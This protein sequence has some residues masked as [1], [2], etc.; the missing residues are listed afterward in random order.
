MLH[1]S[2]HQR[3]DEDWE[4][5]FGGHFTD[6][7]NPSCSGHKSLAEF[8]SHCIGGRLILR[9]MPSYHV[10][11]FNT[12]VVFEVPRLHSVEAV[13][14]ARARYSLFGWWLLE[15]ASRPEAWVLHLK[16]P[17]V[18]IFYLLTSLPA[19]GRGP[20]GSL[21]LVPAVQERRRPLL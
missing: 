1:T 6:L 7:S 14:G 9:G 16:A 20:S 5:S 19:G 11:E 4:P 21:S 8:I 15:D 10:P 13:H 12:L 17:C 2:R 3:I 18:F